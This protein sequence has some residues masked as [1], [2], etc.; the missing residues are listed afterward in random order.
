MEIV[1]KL[2]HE[3]FTVYGVDK[4]KFLIYDGEEFVWVPMEHYRPYDNPVW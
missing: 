2:T 3:R 1:D 4:D